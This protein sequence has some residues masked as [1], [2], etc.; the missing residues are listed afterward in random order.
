LL[1]F[2][3]TFSHAEFEIFISLRCHKIIAQIFKILIKPNLFIFFFVVCVL[4]D[5]FEGW[6][7]MKRNSVPPSTHRKGTLERSRGTREAEHPP[8]RE[9]F[10]S[11]D[12]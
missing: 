9:P 5:V 12:G 4:H 11:S 3:N 7:V 10:T 6:I 8:A 1:Q 2:G